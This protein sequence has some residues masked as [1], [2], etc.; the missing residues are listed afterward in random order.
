[1]TTHING[2]C[3]CGNMKLRLSLTKPASDYTARK[4]GCSF[5]APRNGAHVSDPDGSVEITVADESLWNKHRFGTSTC[6]FMICKGCDGY[7]GAIGETPAGLR[8]VISIWCLETPDLFTKFAA[9]DF[10]GETVESRLAR[11]GRNWT[12]AVLKTPVLNA[13]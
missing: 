8:A 3:A 13:G 10:E 1:M 4:C 2:S 7:L 9:S 5:C 11:R 6:D 12:P